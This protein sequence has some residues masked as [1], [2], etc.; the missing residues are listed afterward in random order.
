[1]LAGINK[2]GCG[3]E[4]D[5]LVVL[6][7]ELLCLVQN[8]AASATR[9]GHARHQMWVTESGVLWAKGCSIRVI[10]NLVFTF[11][12]RRCRRQG[13]GD[14][15]LA[16]PG[17]AWSGSSLL[18]VL[19]LLLCDGLEVRDFGLRGGGCVVALQAGLHVFDALL[20]RLEF[21]GSALDD[22]L[23]VVGENGQ[24][25]FCALC[26]PDRGGKQSRRRVWG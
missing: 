12:S 19:R 3:T 1:M 16:R 26:S 13:P 22:L 9:S 18:L 24:V 4:L 21:R 15:L 5:V 17:C 25:S 6:A 10:K 2:S 20:E 8:I 23:S 7:T 11:T 14:R